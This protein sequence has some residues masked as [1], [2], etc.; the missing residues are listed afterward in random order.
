MDPGTPLG[1]TVSAWVI[2][3]TA[4]VAAQ[5][6][7]DACHLQLHRHRTGHRAPRIIGAANGRAKQHE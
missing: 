5:E 1:A 4:A 2:V 6:A 7:I 3:S